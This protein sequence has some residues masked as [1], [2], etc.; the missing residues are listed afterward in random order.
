MH[1]NLMSADSCM[2][3]WAIDVA[4]SEMQSA[5]SSEQE[6]NGN[7]SNDVGP[8]E[9]ASPSHHVKEI[10]KHY[11]LHDYPQHAPFSFW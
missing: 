4:V 7:D 3:P 10:S 6:D 2:S 11:I 9:R 8:T 5:D 1:L